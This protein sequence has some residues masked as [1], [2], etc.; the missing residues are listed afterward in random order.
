ME[1]PPWLSQNMSLEIPNI[2][3]VYDYLLGGDH[4]LPVDWELV[5][6]IKVVYPDIALAAQVN[7]AF[8]RRVVRFLALQGIDQFLDI[9][10][11]LPT[12]GNVHEIAQQINPDTRIAYVDF[13]PVVVQQ[14]RDI[15]ALDEVQHST[16]IQ[17]DI[18]E[19]ATILNHPD[20]TRLI[21]FRQPIALL[22]VAVLH[23]VVDDTALAQ[24][25]AAFR[26]HM[27]PGSYI[28]ICHGTYDDMPAEIV[29]QLEMLSRSSNAQIRVRSHAQIAALFAG[30]DLLPP[31]LV[32]APLW[33]PE[34]PLD[35]W[36][37]APE[38]PG[39]L[40]GVA[41]KPPSA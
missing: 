11:G 19:P 28:A 2:A 18:R 20:V 35:L 29:M 15:L 39:L 24:I 16:V 13:D 9:G 12:V 27:A 10:S 4:N 26:E 25:V 32:K 40:A 38:R 14:S 31:G 21:D 8:L 23:Y 6:K 17:G 41:R 36:L 30:F 7:R 37:D 1:R 22:L 5:E 3:R 34:G 33:Y